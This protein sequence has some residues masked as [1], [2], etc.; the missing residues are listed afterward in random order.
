MQETI[1]QRFPLQTESWLNNVSPVLATIT[2]VNSINTNHGKTNS[3]ELPL[4]TET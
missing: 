1:P 2:G 3:I 4:L